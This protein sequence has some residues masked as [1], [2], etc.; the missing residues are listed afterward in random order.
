MPVRHLSTPQ[1]N[2]PLISGYPTYRIS[3]ITGIFVSAFQNSR[4]YLGATFIN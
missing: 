3:S 2:T 4:L 1:L